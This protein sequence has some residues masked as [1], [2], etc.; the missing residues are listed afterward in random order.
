MGG[1]KE[2]KRLQAR[3]ALQIPLLFR[4]KE[5]ILWSVSEDLGAGGLFLRSYFPPD[6]DENL[7]IHLQDPRSEDPIVLPARVVHRRQRNKALLLGDEP[8]RPAGAGVA[9]GEIPPT[10]KDRLE[11]LMAA[12]CLPMSRRALTRDPGTGRDED[13]EENGGF[14]QVLD[15]PEEI[16]KLFECLC[17]K[18]RP[19]RLKRLGGQIYYA[20]YFRDVVGAASPFRVQAEAVRLKDFDSVFAEPIPFVFRFDMEDHAYAFTLT[21]QPMRMRSNWSFPLPSRLYYAA[22][23]RNPRYGNEIKHPLTVEFHDPSD[24]SLHRVKTVLDISFGGLAFKNDP[25]EEA[26]SVG[27][28]LSKV[29]IFD[30]DHVCR[31]TDGVVRHASFVCLPDGEVFQKVGIEFAD[32]GSSALKEIPTVREGE[33]EQI[34]SPSSILNHLKKLAASRVDILTGLDHSILFSDGR[35][36]TEQQNG[37]MRL[38]IT[39][40]LLS[41]SP[42]SDFIEARLTY[43]YLFHG[44]YHFFSVRTRKQNGWL[45]LETPTVIHRARRR[46]VVRV[47]PEGIVRTRFRCFHPVMGRR[48]TFPVRD[49]SIRGLSFESDYTRDLF[50]RGIRLRSCEILLGDEYHPLGSVEIRSLVQMVT[51]KGE[52]DRHCGVEFLDLPAE[53]ERIISA[54]IFRRNNPQIKAL[55]AERIE[56]LWELFNRSGFLYPSKKAYIQKI[57]PEIDQTWQKLLSGDMPFYKQ[58]VFREDE[59]ELG[60]ASAV[61]VYE[62]TWLFQHLAASSHPVKLIA[63]HVMMGLAHFLMENRNT[64]YLITYF[65]KENSFPRKVYSGFLEQYPSDDHFCFAKYSFLTLDLEGPGSLRTKRSSSEVCSSNRIVVSHAKEA[66]KEVVESYFQKHFHPLLIRSRSLYRH[67]LHLPETSAMFRAK[68]LKRERSCLVAK[69][70]GTLVAFALL[71]NCSAGINLSGLLNSFSLYTIRPEHPVAREARRALLNAAIDCYRSWKARVAICLAEE[72]DLEDYLDGGFK[73]E[74]EYVCL[75]WSRRMIKG[76]YDYVKERFSRFEERKQR[77]TTELSIP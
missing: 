34:H 28:F 18:I 24:T 16:R 17:R 8:L 44:A 26:Y 69:Q 15:D 31:E 65:R 66:D 11:A 3:R 10:L 52:W 4:R 57:R 60:T 58:I 63:K 6:T 9:F 70:G 37:G 22:E 59:A 40:R 32:Q 64:K 19:V 21:E 7:E 33:L 38:T 71:E 35:L 45:L 27:Q 43:H 72:Q 48:V 49:L 30:F 47:R 13:G 23:R 50:W 1:I 41:Q 62:D 61:Q 46:K 51:E 2:D 39:S 67:V 25:G 53:T 75:S 29:K 42:E 68:G 36:K 5:R 12:E 74:K 73:K 76:Y 20:T 14:Q 56:S 54:Y 77:K 55:T